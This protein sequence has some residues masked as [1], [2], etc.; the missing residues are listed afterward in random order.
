MFL[1]KCAAFIPELPADSCAVCKL[2]DML[3]AEPQGAETFQTLWLDA[4]MATTHSDL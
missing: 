3:V 2:R 4:H 1:P